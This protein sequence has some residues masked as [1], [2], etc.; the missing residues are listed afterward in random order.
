MVLLSPV[1][2]N[3]YCVL[4][5]SE[6]LKGMHLVASRFVAFDANSLIFGDAEALRA[7]SFAPH[8]PS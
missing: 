1:A 5:L 8:T 2:Q 3:N 6:G 4:Q 7:V